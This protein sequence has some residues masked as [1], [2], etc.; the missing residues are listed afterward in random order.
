MFIFSMEYKKS[1]VDLLTKFGIS[2]IGC[3]HWQ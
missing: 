3:E 1:D 2:L